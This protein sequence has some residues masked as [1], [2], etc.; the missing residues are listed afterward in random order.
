MDRIDASVEPPLY[1]LKKPSGMKIK[2]TFYVEDI[3]KIQ[4]DQLQNYLKIDK[5]LDKRGEKF[6]V[7]FVDQPRSFKRWLRKD[8]IV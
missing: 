1:Y 7:N 5:F 2:W 8:Q 6:L 4:E 3:V